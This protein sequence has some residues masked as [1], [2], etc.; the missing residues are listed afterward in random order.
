MKLSVL[1]RKYSP[2]ILGVCFISF[3][4]L[5]WILLFRDKRAL[6]GIGAFY[7]QLH[8][9][10][11]AIQ[12]FLLHHWL[13]TIPTVLFAITALIAFY[14]YI[15]S[16]SLAISLKK[17]ILFS[18]IFGTIMLFSYPI[19][20]TD[21]Y[22]YI[23]SE[24]VGVVH[25]ANIW[26]VKPSV[27]TADPFS[28]FADWKETIS[29]YGGLNY[30]LYL[31][32][33]AIGNNHLIPLLFLYKLLPSLFTL[34]TIYLLYVLLLENKQNNLSKKIRLVLWN[35]LFIL[36]IFG[37]GHNDGIMIFFT[38]LSYYFYRQKRWFWVG[39]SLTLAIQIK[40]IPIVLLFFFIAALLRKKLILASFKILFTFILLNSIFF[41][42]M[43][44]SVFDF[45]QRVFYNGSVYWQSLPNLVRYF[46]PKGAIVITIGFLLW[47]TR[48][49]ALLKK[50]ENPLT[51]YATVLLVYLLFVS[52]AYWNW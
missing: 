9:S 14:C 52:T 21:I 10:L 39:I 23:F 31:L 7:P 34:G 6:T 28:A 15:Q 38:L 46:L 1:S 25:H 42:F 33:S 16:I 11:F 40:L 8:T 19:L 41:I 47:L 49:I 18:I 24:R 13:N 51:S 44:V 35:P 45:L 48:F 5:S 43:R 32:P 4:I 27:F 12:Y 3:N 29:V 22:S 2:Y 37:S 17:T 20:S 26:Q 50:K 30:L 36:E